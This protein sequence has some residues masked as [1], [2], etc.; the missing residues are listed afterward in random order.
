MTHQETKARSTDP[1]TSHD[2][3]AKAGE[4]AKRHQRVILAC[5]VAHGPG[6]K[7]RIATLTHLTG[8]QVARRT[9]EL[10]RLGCIEPTGLTVRSTAGRQ[11]RV[12]SAAEPCYF[13]A[14]GN[15]D[16]AKLGGANA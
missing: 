4:L 13:E 6:S 5:L 14:A 16:R 12:W 7:D 8:T 9:K 1:L 15:V 3:A 10:E 2:A 11:E